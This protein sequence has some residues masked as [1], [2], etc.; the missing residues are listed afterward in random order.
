MICYSVVLDYIYHLTEFMLF[1]STMKLKKINSL[2][3]EWLVQSKYMVCNTNKNT[4]NYDH[5]HHAE[6]LLY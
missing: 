5:G 1:M 3:F 6:F 4:N 2:L